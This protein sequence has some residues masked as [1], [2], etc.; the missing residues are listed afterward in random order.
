[1]ISLQNINS[2][3]SISSLSQY[4]KTLNNSVNQKGFA[5]DKDVW[6]A[7]RIIDK[8][9][10][11]NKQDDPLLKYFNDK[12]YSDIQEI[13]FDIF[14][15]SSKS[16]KTAIPA[17]VID[18]EFVTCLSSCINKLSPHEQIAFAPFMQRYG[19]I[20]DRCK[21]NVTPTPTTSVSN[22]Y[23]VQNNFYNVFGAGKK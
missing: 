11:F 10:E 17:T 21:P 7:E 14:S 18:N 16:S 15:K 9:N 8:A 13:V 12:S 3:F 23:L 4:A 22:N 6:L 20:F 5:D 2:S 1:M 19:H